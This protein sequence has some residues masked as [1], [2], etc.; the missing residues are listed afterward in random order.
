MCCLLATLTR[1]AGSLEILLCSRWV[2][3]HMKHLQ[4]LS[5]KTHLHATTCKIIKW[6]IFIR[7][8]G[9]NLPQHEQAANTTALHH[10]HHRTPQQQST[11]WAEMKKWQNTHFTG[12]SGATTWRNNAAFGSSGIGGSRNI[13]TCLAAKFALHMIII[14]NFYWHS[15]EHWG[16]SSSFFL[17]QTCNIFYFVSAAWPAFGNSRHSCEETH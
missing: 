2:D 12:G 17:S 16:G 14:I 15:R 6:K 9:N 10:H 5:L 8:S 7:S 4:R 1:R 11:I 13:K 3:E